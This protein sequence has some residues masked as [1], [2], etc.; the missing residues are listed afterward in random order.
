MDGS[1]RWIGV[2]LAKF[3][4][5]NLPKRAKGADKFCKEDVKQNALQTVFI[6]FSLF[7]SIFMVYMKKCIRF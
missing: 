1:S 5:I 4:H 3:C 6:L 2:E 7:R